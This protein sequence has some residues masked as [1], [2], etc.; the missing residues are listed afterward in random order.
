M[1]ETM[2]DVR[3][4]FGCGLPEFHGQ[5]QHVHLPVNFPP[6]VAISR[7][8]DSLKGASSRRLRQQFLDLHRHRWRAKRLSSGSYFAGTVGGAPTTVLRR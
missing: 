2:P 1:E 7:L 6:T 3:A 5:A 8:V 4:D